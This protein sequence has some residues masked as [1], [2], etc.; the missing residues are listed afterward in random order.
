MEK[1]S[2]GKGENFKLVG[3]KMKENLKFSNLRIVT[4]SKE[5]GGS[6]AHKVPK[7]TLSRRRLVSVQQQGKDGERGTKDKQKVKK[8]SKSTTSQLQKLL[9]DV[10]TERCPSSDSTSPAAPLTVSLELDS[11]SRIKLF[12]TLLLAQNIYCLSQ[13]SGSSNF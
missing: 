1:S 8:D 13:F 3:A 6:K 7:V 10:P 12:F 2:P 9:I 4:V 5:R 11:I